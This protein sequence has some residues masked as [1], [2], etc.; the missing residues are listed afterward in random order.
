MKQTETITK[1]EEV[2]RVYCDECADECTDSYSFETQEVCQ[3]CSSKTA[4]DKAK[5]QLFVEAEDSD[6]TIASAMFFIL[7]YPVVLFIVFVDIPTDPDTEGAPLLELLMYISGA[8]LWT[9]LLAL[10][11]L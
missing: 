8:S 4:T 6:L 3:S 1:E 5:E 9:L 7:V 11:I 10:V 2:E